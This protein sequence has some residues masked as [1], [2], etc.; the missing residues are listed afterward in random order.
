MAGLASISVI[1]VW[2]E[3]DYTARW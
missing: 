3:I 2:H 1:K